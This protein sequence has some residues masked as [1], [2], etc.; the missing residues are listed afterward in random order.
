MP[1]LTALGPLD[2]TGAQLA[3]V[4]VTIGIRFLWAGLAATL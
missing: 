3:L 4:V 1:T 2:L